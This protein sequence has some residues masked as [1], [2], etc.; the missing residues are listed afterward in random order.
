MI[1]LRDTVQQILAQHREA[2]TPEA[3]RARDAVGS[4]LTALGYRV[5]L[6]R[7]RFHPSALLGLPLLGAGVGASALFALPLL[8]LPGV[9]AAGAL[10]VWV[11]TLA[12]SVCPGFTE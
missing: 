6:Q 8:V 4:H 7:F 12:S 5:S 10:A 11:L 1:A 2:G 9:P 3:E